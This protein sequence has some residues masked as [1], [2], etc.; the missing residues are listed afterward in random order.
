MFKK[1][2]IIILLLILAS[3][4]STLLLQKNIA[5]DWQG[6]LDIRII[7]VIAD[8]KTQTQSFI[9]T[10]KD[11]QFSNI[12]R[13][14]IGQAKTYGI[15]LENSLNI[16][17]EDPIT[18]IPPVVPGH[19]SSRLDIMQWSLKLKWW[20]WKNELP[21]HHLG[22][23]RIY[24]LYQSPVDGYALPHSTGLQN[25]LIGLINARAVAQRRSLHEV[26]ITHELLHIFG[27][28]D[29]YELQNGQPIYP[30][31]YAHP[32]K[33]PLYPQIKA[34]LMGRS[35][36]LNKN[37]SEVVGRFGHT[38]IG[39]KTATEIGWFKNTPLP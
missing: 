23:I 12:K 32:D 18:T 27:A 8:Q 4:S 25:G 21:D 10:L 22:Q 6:T 9:N 5:Q 38:I 35:V 39:N 1:I 11:R 13:Y 3:V 7:P 15:N 26:I 37:K 16:K 34:E 30:D 2:R 31:G 33:K 36:A 29:K 19:E 17:L 24:I 28:S 20:A 14:L